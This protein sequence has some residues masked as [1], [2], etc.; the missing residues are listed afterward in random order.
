M[1]ISIDMDNLSFVH[2]HNDHEVVSAL[3]WLE[4]GTQRSTIVTATDKAR[5]LKT[6]S[7]VELAMLYKNTTGGTLSSA[8]PVELRY[9]LSSVVELLGTTR[10][11]RDEVL[12]QVEAVDDRIHA[13]EVF[14]YARGARTPA[15]PQELFPLRCRPLKTDEL[16]QASAWARS[17]LP[18]QTAHAPS[19]PWPERAEPAYDD[20]T[21]TAMPATDTT[22]EV[23]FVKK[24]KRANAQT[25]IFAACDKAWQEAGRSTD[26]AVLNPLI[27]GLLP[28]LEE[29]GYHPTTSRIKLSKWLKEHTSQ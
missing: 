7:P 15:Q 12:A 10:A 8:D 20:H 4:L 17:D 11:D 5:F 25:E 28:Q 18:T 13:G 23:V 22:P 27:K 9:Q 26:P 16:E 14:R 29:A 1:Y 2:K 21:V 19:G 24:T 3:S 6:L